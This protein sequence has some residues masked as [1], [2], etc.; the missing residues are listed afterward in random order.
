M[1]T[2]Y[3]SVHPSILTFLTSAALSS[4]CTLVYTLQFNIFYMS[5]VEFT[6]YTCVHPSILT[7]LTSA[8]LSLHCTPVYTLL[9]NIF[10]VSC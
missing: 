2:L 7:F 3:A 4:H 10:N 1:F 9:F 8:A 5:Y 6:L